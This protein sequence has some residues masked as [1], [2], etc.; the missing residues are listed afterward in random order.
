MRVCIDLDGV[1]CQLRKEN[2]TYEELSPVKG[3]VEKIK[4]L[5]DEGHYIIIYTAR[6]MKTQN[7]NVG[8]VV[9]NIGLVT[10]EWLDRHSIFYDEIYFGKPWADI[11]IDDNAFRF[12]K[13]ETIDD[14]GKN[15]P[16][17]SEKRIRG[18]E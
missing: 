18:D 4:K 6:N 10:L 17:S 2:Q 8:K 14:D 5:K 11:Y 1:I 3:A 7:A 12:E 13:W 16:L 15:L 9:K